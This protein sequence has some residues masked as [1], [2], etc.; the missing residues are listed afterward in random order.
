MRPRRSPGRLGSR[1]G[2]PPPFAKQIFF[3]VDHLGGAWR[4]PA[5]CVYFDGYVVREVYK[6]HRPLVDPVAV[7]FVDAQKAG[8][9]VRGEQERE[10][11][12]DVELTSVLYPIEELVRGLLDLVLQPP[13][14]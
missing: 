13:A 9:A 10:L 12:A 5:W 11:A 7:F 14:A 1:P 4:H 6:V 8:E 3:V 2:F